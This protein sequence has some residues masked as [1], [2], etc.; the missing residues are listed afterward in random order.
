MLS[1]QHSFHAGNMADVHKHSLLAVS[2]HYLTQKPKPIS[3]IET[4]AGRGLYDLAHP[5]AVKT[6]EA[7]EGILKL[8]RLIP[9]EHPFAQALNRT[10]AR[11]GSTHYPGSPLIAL[12]LLRPEDRI[13]LAERHPQEFKKLTACV[14]NSSG[15]CRQQDGFELAL[16]LCPPTP[17]RGMVFID[18]SYEIKTD[19]ARIPSFVSKLRRR[20]NVGII[21]LWYPLLR[22]D[23]HRA[24]LNRL[25]YQHPEAMR[26]EVRFAPA[27]RSHG[28]I[29]SG[30][31]MI[32][33]PFGLDQETK[34]LNDMFA[35]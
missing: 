16:S 5:D 8:R 25:A 29:G 23:R 24:M 10:Q 9:T 35:V 20:W 22:T 33:A 28:M 34:R 17:R 3:Y 4:H 14:P 11:Y 31:F 15:T 30:M 6:G 21:C 32:N 2:L 19:Y 26:H 18:P 27:N 12:A 1:Y 7:A 13:H